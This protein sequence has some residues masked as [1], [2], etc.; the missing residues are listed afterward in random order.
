MCA[1]PDPSEPR[2]RAFDRLIAEA[3]KPAGFSATASDATCPDAELVAAYAD[4]GLA[5]GHGKGLLRNGERVDLETHFAACERCQKIL[6][7]LGAG[8][9]ASAGESVVVMPAPAAPHVAA[10]P[11]SSS[12]RW[13][14]W[15]TQCLARRGIAVDGA[16]PHIAGW[17]AAVQTAAD[18]PGG[19][20]EA[21]RPKAPVTSTV[22][23][24]PATSRRDLNALGSLSKAESAAIQGGVFDQSGG[25]IVGAKVAIT[26]VD[27]G[28]T[29]NLTTDDAGKY[30]ATALN[31]TF[32]CVQGQR[33]QC[34]GT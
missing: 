19:A 14:W 10:R 8:L 7:A 31:A 11:S 23:P 21:R 5:A 20:A 32:T 28:V 30:V 13:L 12:Q 9:E 34:P 2:D 22:E 27:L 1:K 4:Q 6:A 29:R 15:L 24:S 16:A 17:T 3:L 26:D 25:A 33:V 18:Y